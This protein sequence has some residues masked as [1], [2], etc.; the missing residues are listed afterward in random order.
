MK[1]DDVDD[2]D[3][4][5]YDCDIYREKT[6]ESCYPL[7]N[8]STGLNVISHK[9]RLTLG[10]QH[11]LS[12]PQSRN[13]F[14]NHI[15]RPRR[16]QKVWWHN[17]WQ[18]PLLRPFP[19]GLIISTLMFGIEVNERIRILTKR[20]HLSQHAH[21]NH[22]HELLAQNVEAV[23]NVKPD[24]VV[25]VRECTFAESVVVVIVVVEGLAQQV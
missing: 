15:L 19:H 3:F 4:G 24:D 21:I 23:R 22:A 10:I 13:L 6:G 20:P 1:Q 7:W 16:Y 11:T 9:V 2:L 25:L 8:Y 5:Y 14:I 12:S 17:L 18:L